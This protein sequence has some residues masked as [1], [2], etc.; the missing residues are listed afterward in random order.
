MRRLANNLNNENVS[1]KLVGHRRRFRLER[2]NERTAHLSFVPILWSRWQTPPASGQQT[3]LSV[4]CEKYS[5]KAAGHCQ[6]KK[7]IPQNWLAKKTKNTQLMDVPVSLSL[8]LWFQVVSAYNQSV[9]AL[10]HGASRP[11]F[12]VCR[13]G[14]TAQVRFKKKKEEKRK[15]KL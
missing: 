5:L 15:K 6:K 13:Y 10:Q 12:T 9:S 7:K 11:S 4:I 14:R 1:E 8:G 2:T 3:R